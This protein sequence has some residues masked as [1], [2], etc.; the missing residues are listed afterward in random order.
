MTQTIIIICNFKVFCELFIRCRGKTIKF[1][2]S[3]PFQI[4]LCVL[5]LVDAGVVVSEILLDLHAIRGE[6]IQHTGQSAVPVRKLQ[7]KCL[8]D[9]LCRYSRLIFIYHKNETFHVT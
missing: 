1:L 7:L 9:Y 5:V 8:P 6:C 3:N 2:E 4:V